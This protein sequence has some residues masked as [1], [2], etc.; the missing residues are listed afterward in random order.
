MRCRLLLI[1]LVL[2]TACRRHETP[3]PAVAPPPNPSNFDVTS[4]MSLTTSGAMADQVRAAFPNGV[5]SQDVRAEIGT[6]PA[7]PDGSE[8]DPTA[9]IVVSV[10]LSTPATMATLKT[11]TVAPPTATLVIPRAM[12]STNKWFFIDDPR[13]TGP[14]TRIAISVSF[15]DVDKPESA[16]DID[17]AVAW[18]RAALAKLDPKPASVSMSTSDALA[19]ANAAFELL[20]EIA[21][22]Q[23]D[24]GVRVGAAPGTRFPGRLVW[25]AVYSAGFTYGDGNYFHWVPSSTTDIGQGIGIGTSTG[26]SYFRPE[27]VAKNDGT[28]DVEDLQMSFSI[29]RVAS[30]EAVLDV[31]LRSA[32]YF[33]RRLGGTVTDPDGAPF[34]EAAARAKVA[35]AVQ[36]LK[37]AGLEPGRGLTLQVF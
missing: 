9:E 1:G 6:A 33:A 20:A 30:P 21:D 12:T 35:S 8:P 24:V 16:A 37:A 34:D 22:P 7:P 17:R 25:D 32:R 4:D 10:D 31:M 11:A 18:S 26:S 2:T 27:W 29:P 23:L 36:R 15:I 3:A 5:A 19:R 13:A 28:A 14:F